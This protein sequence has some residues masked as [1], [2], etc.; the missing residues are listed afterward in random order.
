[1]VLRS[2]RSW[3]DASQ[4]LRSPVDDPRFGL[5]ALIG[6]L[7]T[8]DQ[9]KALQE[10]QTSQRDMAQA[11]RDQI[12]AARKDQRRARTQAAHVGGL[13]GGGG[14]PHGNL[15]GGGA[16]NGVIPRDVVVPD[17]I[18]RGNPNIDRAVN[19]NLSQTNP[20]AASLA[21]DLRANGINVPTNA[22]ESIAAAFRSSQQQMPTQ[23]SIRS[24]VASMMPAGMARPSSGG[25]NPLAD[26]IVNAVRNATG[27]IRSN[28]LQQPS[29]ME[30]KPATRAFPGRGVPP[31]GGPATGAPTGTPPSTMPGR[32]QTPTG[33][34]TPAG[35][36]MT[37]DGWNNLRNRKPD[38]TPP[39]GPWDYAGSGQTSLTPT[40]D[41]IAAMARQRM[42]SGNM[43]GLAQDVMSQVMQ[44]VG[45]QQGVGGLPTADALV[46]AIRQAAMSN[47][48]ANGTTPANGQ[49]RTITD[50]RT[51]QP[52][53]IALPQTGSGPQG[54][55][56]PNAAWPGSGAPIA[57]PGTNPQMNIV[58]DPNSRSGYTGGVGAPQGA[59][60]SNV[61]NNGVS[62]DNVN[63]YDPILVDA[64]NKYGVPASLLKAMM[65]I[66]TGGANVCRGGDGTGGGA[67]CGPMQVKGDIWNGLAGCYDQSDVTCNIMTA[68][69]LLKQ[70]YDQT[71]S[72]EGAIRSVYFTQTDTGTGITQDQYVAEAMRLMS[73]V[74]AAAPGGG[75]APAPNG[76]Y[77]QAGLGGTGG[78]LLGAPVG[79]SAPANQPAIP[80]SNA[81]LPGGTFDPSKVFPGSGALM[82][83][84]VVAAAKAQR[85][86][87]AP[88]PANINVIGGGGGPAGPVPIDT[89]VAPLVIDNNPNLRT[90]FGPNA[91]PVATENPQTTSYLD[92]LI[93]G[94]SASYLAQTNGP[95]GK[96][97]Y[98][99][100]DQVGVG[101]YCNYWDWN[102]DAHTGLDILTNGSQE[103]NSLV[104]GKVVCTGEGSNV[105]DTTRSGYSCGSYP[106]LSQGG[107]V[108]NLT[109]QTE[110][111]AMVT[112]GHTKTS[113]YNVGDQVQ[114]GQP[115]GMSGYDSGWHVHLEVRLPIAPDGGY[116]LV[117]PNVYFNNGYC[118]RG[119]C[120]Y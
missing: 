100:K 94:G 35:G 7:N 77:P 72:W 62:W 86:G 27:A 16:G 114:F 65:V 43:N 113:Y 91:E 61:A 22:A 90:S 50:P 83:P 81:L 30:T 47:P 42:A 117:D 119:F 92:S 21:G 102:C 112:Y 60:Q 25:S 18:K 56:D 17:A 108:G 116:V 82:D 67:S 73:V 9:A 75:T 105:A 109:I 80:G 48:A 74:D 24:L 10:M 12:Q 71:G 68:A 66:E 19:F 103:F 14:A 85:D 31:G 89:T 110:D 46:A 76:Q 69:A 29:V 87:L 53:V 96:G 106:D 28:P 33:T 93:P 2:P 20:H 99:F 54:S 59:I 79:T 34:R 1:M 15:S 120:A 41:S 64:Q 118:D 98:G 37:D 111:G 95:N 6:A 5:D 52:M 39:S 97:P 101:Q 8:L 3:N 23:E 88:P 36:Q 115:I 40:P 45:Q 38:T 58:A 51:G 70:G 13:A 4:L 57:P 11:Q 84:A 26:R 104:S 44:S 55:F 32:Q 63:Q 78:P 107:G 49:Y